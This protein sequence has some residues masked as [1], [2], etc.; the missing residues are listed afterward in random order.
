MLKQELRIP[1][2]QPTMFCHLILKTMDYDNWAQLVWTQNLVVALNYQFNELICLELC[3]RPP[4]ALYHP[5]CVCVCVCVSMC[6]CM[7]VCV[8]VCMCMCIHV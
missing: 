5:V 3:C 2:I 4:G 6:V 8:H 7:C 1:F